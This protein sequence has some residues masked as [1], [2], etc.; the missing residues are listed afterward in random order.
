MHRDTD[1][2]GKIANFLDEALGAMVQET[3]VWAR[4]HEADGRYRDAE[5]FFR[6]ASSNEKIPME[7]EDP[8]QSE[9][10]LPTL[11]SIYEKMGDYPA[12]EIVQEKLLTR[13]FAKTSKQNTEE[14]IREVS[15]YSR[16]L[17]H[18]HKRSLDL[19][20]DD[21]TSVKNY[22]DFFIVYRVA[23]FDIDLLNEISLE[24][25]L[26][27]LKP[28]KDNFG[29]SL[30]IAARENAINLAQLLLEKGAD[31]NSRDRDSC[32]PLHIA[33][34]YAEPA[35]TELLLANG[36]ESQV[37]KFFG[38]STL[39]AALTEKSDD[40]TLALLVLAQV[41]M[42]ARDWRGRT[43]LTIAVR[44]D[45]PA[46]A[47]SLL[48]H[49]ANAEVSDSA[50][51]TL[52]ITAVRTGKEWATKL[53]LE[54][55]ANLEGRDAQGDTALCVAVKKGQKT[56]VQ[57]LLDHGAMTKT[58]VHH[59]FVPME[60]LLHCAV[61]AANVSIAEKLLKAGADVYGRDCYGNTMLHRAVIGIQGPPESMTR[62]LLRYS[63]PLDAVNLYGNTVFH[64][65]FDTHE[66]S[67]QRNMFLIFL[68]HMNPDE[69][70]SVCQIGDSHG[71]TPLV[72]ARAR[73]KNTKEDSIERS[74]LYLLENALKLSHS[75]METVNR[76]N[77]EE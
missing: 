13:L 31:I 17:F 5:Y 58:I 47:R 9:D 68:R 14:Q 2:E 37:K 19:G 53:L 45:S 26:I 74:I 69:L 57:I 35:M 41:D 21:Q 29:T 60:T 55:G 1:T 65:A 70:Y 38:T 73:T 66:R 24:Q 28:Y 50:R 75:Y 77:L 67:R 32:T 44:R 23:V 3:I 16:L 64:L 36:S 27:P 20:F 7:S 48:Q 61:R 52:L 72:I 40:Q 39:H 54:K 10:V 56:I 30:H 63:A 71:R 11:V 34:E 15:A 25:G 49:G 76:N 4:Q 42:E 22:I 33:A 18:F 12:A 8:Y 51:E 46:V 59:Q 62:L 43:A 6:R